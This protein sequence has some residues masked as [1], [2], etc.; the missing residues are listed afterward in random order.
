MPL[1]SVTI[2]AKNEAAHIAGC[3]ES[4]AGISNDILLADSG[5]SDGT[6]SIA[7]E[8]GAKVVSLEWKGYG[9]TRNEAALLARHDWILSLDADERVTAELAAAISQLNLQNDKIIYGFKRV[10]FLGNKRVRYGEW[11]RDKVFRLYNKR[12]TQWD[13]A[14]VHE[15]IESRGMQKQMIV[16]DL[17]HYTMKDLAEYKAKSILYATLSAKKY[18]AAGKKASLVK[19]FLSPV[20]SFLQNYVFRAGFLDGATG[21]GIAC[22]SSYYVYLKYKFLH[23]ANKEKAKT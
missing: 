15:N 11:G 6:M 18:A 4:V 9:G 23:Q 13:A 2:I 17:L 5:S 10:N 21:F 20:F 12:N 16:G 7:R 8:A 22:F 1:F 3:V 19:R 14:L